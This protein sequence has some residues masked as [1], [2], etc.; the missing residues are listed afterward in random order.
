MNSRLAENVIVVDLVALSLFSCF[1]LKDMH[2]YALLNRST[3]KVAHKLIHSCKTHEALSLNDQVKNSVQLKAQK[4][5]SC[6]S[7]KS[8]EDKKIHDLLKQVA[9]GKMDQKAIEVLKNSNWE[10]KSSGQEFC[11]EISQITLNGAKDFF[12]SHEGEITK[13]EVYVIAFLFGVSGVSYL[14]N[15]TIAGINN[16]FMKPVK[17]QFQSGLDFFAKNAQKKDDTDKDKDNNNEK[18][19]EQSIS[20]S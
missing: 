11:Q 13:N 7:T 19:S 3:A 1:E 17:M 16:W 20:P 15:L 9:D 14:I 2:N 12:S 10:F 6:T 5:L 18:K 4:L 8:E